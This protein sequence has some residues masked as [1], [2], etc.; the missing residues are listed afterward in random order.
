MKMK[1]KI[2]LTVMTLCLVSTLVFANRDEGMMPAE[3]FFL[4][5]GDP[6]AGEA[7]FARLRC[8]ACHWVRNN[9]N[10]QAPVAD[11]IGPLLGPKQA[12][13]EAGWIANSIVTPSHTI[14]IRSNGEADES[15]L[16]RMGD[17]TETMTV[18]ELMNLVAFL[19]TLDDEDP[20]AKYE[21]EEAA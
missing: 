14:A 1:I 13:Y 5:Q 21:V 9:M 15:E 17:F 4:Q 8:D 11:K 10:L 18:K 16:S 7:A 12:G 20:D 19:Q 2:G 6:Q 3:G